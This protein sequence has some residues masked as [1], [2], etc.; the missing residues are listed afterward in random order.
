MNRKIDYLR[1]SLTDRCNL[2]CVYC[3][4]ASRIKKVPKMHIIQ[5]DEICFLLS[6]MVEV[7]IKKIRFTG[8]E[9]LVRK[10][11][12]ILIEKI[13]EISGIEDKSITTNGILFEKYSEELLK[14]GIDRVNFSIDSL[15]KDKFLKVTGGGKL[16]IVMNSL[17]L[18]MEMDFRSVKVNTVLMA[19]INNDEIEE[20]VEYTLTNNISY[21]LQSLSNTSFLVSSFILLAV[22]PFFAKYSIDSSANLPFGKAIVILSFIFINSSN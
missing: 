2:N 10:D 21:C 9:P 6:I 1:L 3:R 4:P 15:N 7:G 11:F 22:I 12:S 8:G 17:K 18:A 19:D 14:F 16:K 20:M 5:R 13:A